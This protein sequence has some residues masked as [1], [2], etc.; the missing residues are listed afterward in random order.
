MSD[1]ERGTVPSEYPPTFTI[2][3]DVHDDPSVILGCDSC[4]VHFA[5]GSSVSYDRLTEEVMVHTDM[6]LTEHVSGYR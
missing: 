3:V 1:G 4:G 5:F 6:H 2:S